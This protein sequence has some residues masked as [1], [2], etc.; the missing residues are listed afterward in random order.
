MPYPIVHVLF[1]LFCVGAA[2]V[3]AIT[4]TLFRRELSSRNSIQLLLIAYIGGMC[5][6]FPDLPAVY[7][8]F[9]NGTLE[10]ISIGSVPTHSLLFS[11][12]AIIFGA[13]IEYALYRKAN[14]A[15]YMAIFAESAF[16]TH[17][18]LDD[19]TEGGCPYLYPLYDGKIS[20]FSIMDTGFA[21]AGSL[22]HY[23]TVSIVPVFCIFSVIMMALFA[24]YKLGFELS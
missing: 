19:I 18:L 8:L 1:F 10:H 3:F 11:S 15:V 21:E 2:A 13:V 22:F 24:L 9:S 5:T 17:L 23:L 4:K 20:V 12:T 6:L 7:N 14:K 16:L